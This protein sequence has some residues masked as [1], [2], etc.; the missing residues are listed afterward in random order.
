[1][2]KKETGKR[3]GGGEPGEQ[4]HKVVWYFER[5]STILKDVKTL[6]LRGQIG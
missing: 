5:W 1:M 4:L 3:E 6:L 2:A